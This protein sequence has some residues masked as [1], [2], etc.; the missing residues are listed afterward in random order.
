MSVH[1]LG[2][3]LKLMSEVSV[4]P[5]QDIDF[6]NTAVVVAGLAGILCS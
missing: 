2:D 1:V 5:Y 3:Y 4:M 6:E